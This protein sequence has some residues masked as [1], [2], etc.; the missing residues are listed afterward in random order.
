M[1]AHKFFAAVAAAALATCG[2]LLAGPAAATVPANPVIVT[3][4]IQELIPTS[5]FTAEWDAV[6]GSNG[7][8]QYEYRMSDSGATDGGGMLLTAVASGV[9]GSLTALIPAMPDGQYYFQVRA[10]DDDGFN[11]WTNSGYRVFLID[12][13]APVV[14]ITSALPITGSTY[15][16]T[17]DA[18]EFTPSTWT[19][20]IDGVVVASGSDLDFTAPKSFAADLD[21]SG[22]SSGDHTLLISVTDS[23]DH[24]GTASAD[25]TVTTLASTGEDVTWPLVVGSALVLGGVLALGMR[26]RVTLSA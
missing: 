17:F 24:T 5:S 21:L 1:R 16:L 19:V 25:F 6:V 3:P 4:S 10:G 15:A 26:R 23:L 13:T 22:L 7:A 14:T 11:T 20:E 18:D 9:T 2:L 12:T 8:T